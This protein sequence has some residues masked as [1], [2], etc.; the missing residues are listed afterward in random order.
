M[1]EDFS[2]PN[3]EKFDWDP[4]NIEHIKKHKVSRAEC[5]EVFLGKEPVITEDETH[6]Q[7][8]ERYRIFGQTS[9]GRL[10]FMIMTIRNNKIR[11]ISARDQNKKERKE[12]LKGGEYI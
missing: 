10:L 9:G 1:V 8:E 11:I 6:S 4:G 3:L 7:K 2:L 12:Y 5:E